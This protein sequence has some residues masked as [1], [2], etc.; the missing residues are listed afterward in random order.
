MPRYRF[1]LTIDGNTLDEVE[2]ELIAQARSGFIT[3][4]RYYERD[5]WHA[6]G[7]K[8][9]RVMEHLNPDMTPER[10]DRELSEWWERRKAARGEDN[11]E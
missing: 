2:D 3:D 7:G 8:V 5:E 4:S 6:F 9:T 10:Y 11:D 1:T